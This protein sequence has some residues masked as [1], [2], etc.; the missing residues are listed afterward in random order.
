MKLSRRASLWINEAFDRY[1]PP[2]MRDSKM[3]GNLARRMYGDLT[4]DI[5]ELKDKA[6]YLSRAEFAAF[7]QSLRSRFDQGA[8][9]QLTAT[10]DTGEVS[11]DLLSWSGAAASCPS[12]GKS[13]CLLKRS[14]RL[15]VS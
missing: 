5:V 15:R 6:F 2:S 1:L 4:I 12:A 3:F 14:R 13:P 7:Y 10:G 11:D 8:T 9:V